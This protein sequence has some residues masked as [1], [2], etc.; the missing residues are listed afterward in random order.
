MK[1]YQK[2]VFCGLKKNRITHS[3]ISIMKKK[4]LKIAILNIHQEK[5]N[6]GAEVFVKELST[7]LAKKHT[8]HIF[9]AKKYWNMTFPILWRFFLDPLSISVLFF[10]IKIL[11]ALW[12]GK[13][14]IIMP[15][16]SGW[17]PT[18]I[19]ILTWIR[20][21]KVVISGQSGKGWYDRI[22]INSFSD[23]FVALSTWMADWA[24]KVNPFAKVAV[25]PNGVDVK[26]F[27]SA[28]KHIYDFSGPIILSVGALTKNKR[29]DLTIKAVSKMK[30]ASLVIVGKGEDKERLEKLGKEL[31]SNRFKI[32]S[33]SHRDMPAMYKGADI[34]TFPT[35]AWESFG[36]VLVEA[37]AAGLPVVANDDP[38]RR[39]IVGEAGIFVDPEK[40]DLYVN[41]LQRALK[42]D[43]GTKS[44]T[45][46][47][48]YDWDKIA[49]KYEDLFYSLVN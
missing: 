15:L 11:P 38:I 14:D 49:K 4:K 17:Q 29:H 10:T 42:E 34:F 20:G 1:S 3:I 36:I 9:S 19:R 26:T 7:R 6:R 40:T 12:I 16:N 18:I 48:K 30:N 8:V 47:K 31:L 21:G 28:K 5:V 23:T 41:A 39:E 44:V 33:A 37:M 13:Y 2:T 32:V 45:Q 43:W 27:G 22:N 46:A 35:V 25:I 24:Q